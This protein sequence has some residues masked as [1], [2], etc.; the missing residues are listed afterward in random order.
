MTD[1]YK[2]LGVDSSKGIVRKAFSGIIDNDYPGAFVNIIKDPTR[3][4]WVT[5]SH[6]D[7]DGSKSI[8]R[9][10]YFLETGNIEIFGGMIDDGMSMNTSD[11]SAS[12]FVYGYWK[13]IDCLNVGLP[14]GKI[15]K[16]LMKILSM[17]FEELKK[18]YRDNGFIFYFLGGETADLPDNVLNIAFDIS[19]DAHMRSGGVIRGNV[20]PGDVIYGLSSDGRASWEREENSGIMSN[21]ITLARTLMDVG[22]NKKY[23]FLRRPGGKFYKGRFKVG[24]EPEGL[25]MEIS[26]AILSPTR[27]WAIFIRRLMD[28]LKKTKAEH[29]LHGI[30][31]NTGGGA[32]KIRNVGQGGIRY[33]KGMIEPP[34]IFQLIKSETGEGWKNMFKTFNCGVG[35]DIIGKRCPE[36]YRAIE[37]AANHSMINFHTLGKCERCEGENQVILETAYGT[38]NY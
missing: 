31:V 16:E 35:L 30:S 7:G 18:L 4:G 38:F 32:T 3:K 19:I 34:P 29:T 17:R 37:K 11:I 13:I 5:T 20:K 15:K 22:Y 14:A 33:I 12:G 26:Q 25:G 36:L 6:A 28:E 8:Q 23:P 1:L 21:G 9:F 10:L 24:D 27:Q 2:K